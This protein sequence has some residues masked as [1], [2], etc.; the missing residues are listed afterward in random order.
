MIHG[1]IERQITN[2]DPSVTMAR[3]WRRRHEIPA[4]IELSQARTR[5][6]NQKLAPPKGGAS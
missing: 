5:Q 6:T 1:R 4:T 2:E 3:P